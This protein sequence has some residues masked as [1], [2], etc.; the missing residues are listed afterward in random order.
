LD[1][2]FITPI[3]KFGK[4]TCSLDAPG[5]LEVPRGQEEPET[6]EYGISSFVFRSRRPFHPKRLSEA[7]DAGFQEGLLQG[8]L[9]SK[10]IMWIASRDIWAYDW[11]QAGCSV[12]MNPAGYWWAAVTEEEW[13]EDPSAVEEIRKNFE[14]RHGDRRQEL[15]FIG[16]QM[17]ETRIREILDRCLLSDEEFSSGPEVWADYDD[18]FPEIQLADEEED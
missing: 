16:N 5:W 2:L 15:V 6:L 9:R 12:R 14:G 13:P 7:I 10:G 11:S 1:A 3:I 17:D 18:P 8:V 4:S